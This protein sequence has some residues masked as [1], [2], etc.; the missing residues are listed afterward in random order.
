M[1]S[2]LTNIKNLLPYFLLIG[3]YFF[4][5]N[6]EARKDLEENQNKKTGIIDTKDEDQTKTIINDSGQRISIPVVPYNQ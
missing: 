3:I 1:K 4:F 5:V 6:I 2:I